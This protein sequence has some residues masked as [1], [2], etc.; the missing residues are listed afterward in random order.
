M[1]QN[2][3]RGAAENV[4]VIWSA[5]RGETKVAVIRVADREIARQ[6]HQKGKLLLGWNRCS[7]YI[8]II[9]IRCSRC[10]KFGHTERQCSSYEPTCTEC[11]KEHYH[12][13]CKEKRYN[14]S[15]CKAEGTT[16]RAH[17][18]WCTEC[19]IYIRRYKQIQREMGLQCPSLLC[20]SVY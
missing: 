16:E 20:F 4:K 8:N 5:A 13:E 10:A 11:G 1:E 19:P 18:M 2:K 14:C 15:A 7:A 3:L 12:K 6:I 17:S 9:V